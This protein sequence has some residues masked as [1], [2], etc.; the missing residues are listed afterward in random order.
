MKIF[1]IIIASQISSIYTFTSSIKV[2]HKRF[3]FVYLNATVNAQIDDRLVYLS[4]YPS[5]IVG[6]QN[7]LRYKK[8][9]LNDSISG[10]N[11]ISG[12]LFFC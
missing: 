6:S 3:R 11:I 4:Y 8:F 9:I 12:K 1:L 5:V 2:T 10:G 7:T